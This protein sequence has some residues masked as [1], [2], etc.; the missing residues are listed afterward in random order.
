MYLCT[1]LDLVLVVFAFAESVLGQQCQSGWFQYGPSCYF[2]IQ[3]AQP[4][5]DNAATTCQSIGAHLASIHS[6]AVNQFLWHQA[7]SRLGATGSIWI[8][9]SRN[10]PAS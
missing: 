2:I 4:P 1:K 7:M 9:L 6:Q 10:P 3:S 8:G 5:W